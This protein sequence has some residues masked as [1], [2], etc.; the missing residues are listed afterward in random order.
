MYTHTLACV[1][2]KKDLVQPRTSS[3]CL[4]PIFK[5][6]QQKVCH[7]EAAEV[8][9]PHPQGAGRPSCPGLPVVPQ[10]AAQTILQVC[11]VSFLSSWPCSRSLLPCL[12]TLGAWAACVRFPLWQGEPCVEGPPC[13]VYGSE[14]P[15]RGPCALNHEGRGG[16][17]PSRMRR[18]DDLLANGTLPLLNA[19][20]SSQHLLATQGFH[21][22]SV[23]SEHMY[24]NF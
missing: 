1:Q 18:L 15:P 14:S 7:L 4:S 17:V 3:G 5:C 21:V 2:N 24:A 16:A 6:F 20:Q 22:I 19:V 12:S 10:G 9:L 11:S 8:V 13:A 23:I